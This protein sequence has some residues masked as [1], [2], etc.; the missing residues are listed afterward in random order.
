MGKVVLHSSPRSNTV[1][2]HKLEPLSQWHIKTGG[3]IQSN[4]QVKYLCRLMLFI[5]VMPSLTRAA[6]TSGWLAE[7]RAR[8]IDKVAPEWSSCVG[9]YSI[10][11][12]DHLPWINLDSESNHGYI[13]LND[14]AIN[15]TD[16]T[17]RINPLVK[18]VKAI[19]IGSP[20]EELM[21]RIDQL[22]H[23]FALKVLF[24]FR[25]GAAPMAEFS[26]SSIEVHAFEQNADGTI[27]SLSLDYY[28]MSSQNCLHSL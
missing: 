1:P 10:P 19:L 7:N 24:V 28:K 3:R 16:S 6:M 27:P 14:K 11:P 12:G 17:N 21:S 8:I 2:I 23:S 25:D 18:C 9:L 15:A 20:R 22:L 4:M 26:N 5:S 13:V